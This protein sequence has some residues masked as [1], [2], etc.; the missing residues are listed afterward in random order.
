MFIVI[1]KEVIRA[2]R[3]TNLLIVVTKEL[4]CATKTHVNAYCGS[5]VVTKEVICATRTHV[6][7]YC[8]N[9]GAY[10][11]NKSQCDFR[12]EL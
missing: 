9:Q 5:I 4:I 1:T 8:G 12:F 2:T 7:A 10:L 3:T 11:H 6:I